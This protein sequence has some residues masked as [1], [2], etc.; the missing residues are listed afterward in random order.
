MTRGVGFGGGAL[1]GDPPLG[2]AEFS[3]GLG[4]LVHGHRVCTRRTT[5]VGAV[6]AEETWAP[7]LHCYFGRG[8]GGRGDAPP[9]PRPPPGMAPGAKEVCGGRGNRPFVGPNTTAHAPR[10]R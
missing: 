1:G 3:R 9:P 6:G 2:D 5:K 8:G 4:A 7:S 10:S